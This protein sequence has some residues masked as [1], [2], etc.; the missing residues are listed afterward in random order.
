MRGQ[1]GARCPTGCFQNPGGSIPFAAVQGM[2][3]E[4][5][6]PRQYDCTLSRDCCSWTAESSNE[7]PLQAPHEFLLTYLMHWC[8]NVFV[9]WRCVYGGKS[10]SY[11]SISLAIYHIIQRTIFFPRS[12]SHDRRNTGV[13]TLC[14]ASNT[15]DPQSSAQARVGHPLARPCH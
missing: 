10:G 8:Q 4:R 9:I 3:M 2:G 5:G 14:Y 6:A 15:G 7:R 12:G 13:H 11:D 1:F